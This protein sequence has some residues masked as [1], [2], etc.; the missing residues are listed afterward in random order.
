[1]ISIIIPTLNEENHIGDLLQFLTQHPQN[2]MFEII[3]VDGHS[4]D[5]TVE[6][7]KTFN[8]ALYFSNPCSRALQMNDGAAH[9]KGDI[10][11][12]VHADVHLIPSFVDDIF[13]SVGQGF[14]SG[15]FRFKFD[16]PT[17][18]LLHINSFFTRFPFRW[19]RGGDQTLFITRKAF[20]RVDGFNERYVIMEDYELLDR[21]G[22]A[23]I[24]FQVIPKSIKVSARKYEKNSYLKVQ[25]ANLKAMKMYKKGTNPEHIKEFYAQA[26]N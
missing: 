26:L 20:D 5:K 18:P 2:D 14:D 4:G 21:L 23:N 19:C 10:L 13:Q 24:S 8:T 6:I 7:V 25:T 9:A 1:M 15:C 17:N 12:F 3:V 16:R 22:E 11:Y